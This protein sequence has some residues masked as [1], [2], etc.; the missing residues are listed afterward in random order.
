MSQ[1]Y[2]TQTITSDGSGLALSDAT[3]ASAPYIT[4]NCKSP[5]NLNFLFREVLFCDP[6]SVSVNPDDALTGSS[7]VHIVPTYQDQA[8]AE[9]AA[10]L[11]RYADVS[12]S[13]GHFYA[14]RLVNAI[15]R[16]ELQLSP[17]EQAN[18]DAFVKHYGGYEDGLISGTSVNSDLASTATMDFGEFFQVALSAVRNKETD[19][20]TT[21]TRGL[22][23]REN[24]NNAAV[25]DDLKSRTVTNV[26]A[27]DLLETMLL[28]AR[29]SNTFANGLIDNSSSVNWM[30]QLL[31]SIIIQSASGNG[32][33]TETEGDER[34]TPIKRTGVAN[35]EQERFM[36]LKLKDGDFIVIVFQ[37]TVS[38]DD[39]TL[40]NNDRPD[41]VGVP[42]T[43]GF[44]IEHSDTAGDYDTADTG[45]G[46]ILPIGWENSNESVQ[47]PRNV[48]AVVNPSSHV[49]DISWDQPSGDLVDMTMYSVSVEDTQSGIRYGKNIPAGSTSTSIGPVSPG[50]HDII[51]TVRSKY[52]VGGSII[53]SDPVSVI[54]VSE[55]LLP[56]A[57]SS[58]AILANRNF[59]VTAEGQHQDIFSNRYSVEITHDQ[60]NGVTRHSALI[61]NFNTSPADVSSHTGI[62]NSKFLLINGVLG[63]QY[64]IRVAS[65]AFVDGIWYTGPYGESHTWTLP[66]FSGGSL[67][68]ASFSSSGHLD[69][70]YTDIPAADKIFVKSYEVH[71]SGAQSGIDSGYRTNVPTSSH[72]NNF[73][74][75][76]GTYNVFVRVHYSLAGINF[77]HDSATVSV[78]KP[79]QPGGPGFNWSNGAFANNIKIYNFSGAPAGATYY[80]NINGDIRSTG[81]GDIWYDNMGDNNY[82]V[83]VW[84]VHGGISSQVHQKWANI[85]WFLASSG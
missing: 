66:A 65:Q 80:V 67:T 35:N 73:T 81:G 55:E 30:K 12:S 37:F 40:I 47:A 38:K 75:Y 28:S 79:G 27:S 13:H 11:D 71:Y 74:S 46:G 53:L 26:A 10:P 44:K 49:V 50:T 4:Y 78:T 59:T 83:D 58:S 6:E 25:V 34:Y 17:A 82:A 69:L 43:I 32:S 84:W 5:V 63:S 45:T 57:S 29:Q 62:F 8:A 14:M 54:T 76:G 16:N 68:G 61:K 64:T 48:G 36:Q 60:A 20:I 77:F 2:Y 22:V 31:Y 7:K 3:Q 18:L 24:I 42:I 1:T 39:G 15:M 51:V 19:A 21:S 33:V 72:Y 70:L 85:S 56:V 41:E 23:D 9:A 52:N